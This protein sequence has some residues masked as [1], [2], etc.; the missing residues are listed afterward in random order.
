MMDLT[1]VQEADLTRRKP[2]SKLLYN[3]ELEFRLVQRMLLLLNQ[4]PP[5]FTCSKR[6]SGP[7]GSA[8]GEEGLNDCLFNWNAHI[9]PGSMKFSSQ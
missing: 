7:F 2:K 6:L 1:G 4:L 9:P 5:R 3:G 8:K